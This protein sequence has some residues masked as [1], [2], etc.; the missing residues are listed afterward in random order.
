MKQTTGAM[1][2]REQFT[3]M[4]NDCRFLVAQEWTSPSVTAWWSRA[5]FR[6]EISKKSIE[7]PALV[8]RT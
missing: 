6:C 8:P 1:N 2:E 5:I 7:I 3:E 4:S